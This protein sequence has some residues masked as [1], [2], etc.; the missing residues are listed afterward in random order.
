VPLFAVFFTIGSIV[1]ALLDLNI[2][3]LLRAGIDWV[4]IK[5]YLSGTIL[6]F[7]FATAF[8]GVGSKVSFHS[9]LGLGA[10]PILV[11]A[12]V[13]VTAGLLAFLSA[14]LLVPFITA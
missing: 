8:A 11:A 13:A 2:D 4:A 12:A 14:V 10:R 1:C 9:I 6:P 5:G 7:T 3:S